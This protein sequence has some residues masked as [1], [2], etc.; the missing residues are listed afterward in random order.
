MISE[1]NTGKRKETDIRTLGTKSERDGRFPS[2]VRWGMRS[3]L[4]PS[5]LSSSLGFP[6]A[7]ASGWKKQKKTRAKAKKTK[8]KAK[9]TEAKA[10]KKEAK[11][12]IESR[13]CKKKTQRRNNLCVGGW[14]GGWGGVLSAGPAE[15]ENVSCGNTA[16]GVHLSQGSLPPAARDHLA[17]KKTTT[18]TATLS[19]TQRLTARFGLFAA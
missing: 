16:G 8:A 3:G 14:V 4:Q 7:S 6:I 12:F 15:A 18:T 19:S 13:R 5:R 17:R 9:K 1:Q 11:S 10:K 2:K